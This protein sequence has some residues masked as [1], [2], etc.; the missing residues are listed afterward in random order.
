MSPPWHLFTAI[1][2]HDKKEFKL[3]VKAICIFLAIKFYKHILAIGL[4]CTDISAIRN[5][6]MALF[7]PYIQLA[8]P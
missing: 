2:V 5:K 7:K 3:S 8:G 6:A 4:T 1:L